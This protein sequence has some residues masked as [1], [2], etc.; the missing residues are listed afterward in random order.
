MSPPAPCG[1]VRRA[2]VVIVDDA[3]DLRLLLEAAIAQDGRLQVVAAVGDGL[4]A[5]E[6]VR[7]HQPDVVLMD[8]SMPVLDG[9]A[10]T[11]TLT[12]EHPGLPV[13]LFTGYADDVLAH[14]AR[15]AGAVQLIGKDVPVSAVVEALLAHLAP[16]DP[17]A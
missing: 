9:I 6:A 17:A 3:P 8:V 13:V 7:R 5:V 10:A 14:T 15:A 11:R 12:T 2:T 1:V 4:A 16:P